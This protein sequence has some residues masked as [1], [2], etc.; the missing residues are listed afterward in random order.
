MAQEMRIDDSFR[1]RE[2]QPR[3]EII[4]Y[5]FPDEDSVGFADFHGFDPE[6]K[7]TSSVNSS[8]TREGTRGWTKTAL[9]E[10]DS[11]QFTDKKLNRESSRRGAL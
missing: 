5:L 11:R 4:F 9:E 10:V 8:Q 7:L 2:V 3:R 1:N 6:R